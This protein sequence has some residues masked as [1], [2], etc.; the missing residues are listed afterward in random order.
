MSSISAFAS[1]VGVLVG[2]K[3]S[4]V[5]SITCALTAGIKTHEP[6]IKK[7]S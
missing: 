6:I 7:K 2:I 1:S 3:S 4:A 5:G